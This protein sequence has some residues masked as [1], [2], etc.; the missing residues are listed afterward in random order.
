MF[1]FIV[2]VLLIEPLGAVE[3]N[4]LLSSAVLEYAFVRNLKSKGPWVQGETF[5]SFQGAPVEKERFQELLVVFKVQD[6]VVC[7]NS[8]HLIV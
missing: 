1:C 3:G 4:E 2:V 8:I 7:P 5:G 6:Y